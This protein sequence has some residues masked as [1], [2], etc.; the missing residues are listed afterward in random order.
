MMHP[1]ELNFIWVG[2]K[3]M[4][5][6]QLD[7]LDRIS[8]YSND[9][10]INI[11]AIPE[12]LH[13]DLRSHFELKQY[14]IRNIDTLLDANVAPTTYEIVQL[15]KISTIYSGLAD[16]LKFLI[17][18]RPVNDNERSKRFYME[19]DN[20]YPV[21]LDALINSRGF[22]CHPAKDGIRVDS[23]YVDIETPIGLK[24]KKSVITHTESFLSDT[25]INQ[26]INALIILDSNLSKGDVLISFGE[27][28]ET[29]LA[30]I[31]HTNPDFDRLMYGD[32]FCRYGLY[33]P[34]SWVGK[35]TSNECMNLPALVMFFRC[36][37]LKY[38][39]NHPY[40]T[41]LKGSACILRGNIPD[42]SHKFS[43]NNTFEARKVYQIHNKD[44]WR[45]EQKIVPIFKGMYQKKPC[46]KRLQPYPTPVEMEVEKPYLDTNTIDVQ[47]PHSSKKEYTYCGLRRGF[48]L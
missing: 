46:W 42:L 14:S 6:G 37:E 21:D 48:L 2:P 32:T 30:R 39:V 15:L 3:K 17:L 16:I 29:L 18:A 44:L 11:W 27:I 1:Y 26:C 31:M 40:L 7:N 8:A 19:A 25:T 34:L 38:E 9:L 10:V 43:D 20:Q 47:Q 4:P 23:F 28:N 45:S 22:L 41:M 5:Q 33:S 36:K 13:P 35:N 24:F 12:Q